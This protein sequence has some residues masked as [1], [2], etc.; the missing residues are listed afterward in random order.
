MVGNNTSNSVDALGLHTIKPTAAPAKPYV[1]KVPDPERPGK[2]KQKAGFQAFRIEILPAPECTLKVIVDINL[3][4]HD[5]NADLEK[6]KKDIQKGVD[7]V[8]NNQFIFSCPESCAC[9][10]VKVQVVVEFHDNKSGIAGVEAMDAGSSDN[11]T[12][13]SWNPSQGLDK[14][15]G[16]E[17]GHFLGNVDEYGKVRNITSNGV[18]YGP[19]GELSKTIDGEGHHQFPNPGGDQ[20]NVMNNPA[21]VAQERHFDAI[22]KE[23]KVDRPNGPRLFLRNKCKFVPAGNK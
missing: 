9:P 1:F 13:L 17:I 11:S 22:L 8:W 5:E 20:N 23:L 18:P 2:W 7:R 3:H 4:T 15:A 19:F 12:Q 14:V 16:H 21:G 6:M 10:T